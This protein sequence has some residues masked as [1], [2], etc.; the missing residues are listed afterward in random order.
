MREPVTLPV[1]HAVP[2]RAIRGKEITLSASVP[3][4]SEGAIL[5]TLTVTV[6]GDTPVTVT[7]RETERFDFAEGS[8]ASLTA[9]LPA[10]LTEACETVV[11]T[12]ASDGTVLGRYEVPFLKTRSNAEMPPL[13]FTE[14]V[15]R[16]SSPKGINYLE[17]MNPSDKTVDLYDYKLVRVDAEELQDVE[18]IREMLITNEKGTFLAPGEV[19]VLRIVPV[20]VQNTNPEFLSVEAFVEGV[21]GVCPDPIECDPDAI[22]IVNVVNAIPDEETGKLVAAPGRFDCPIMPGRAPHTI[23]ITARDGKPTEAFHSLTYGLVPFELETPTRRA[24]VWGLDPDCPEKAVRLSAAEFMTPGRLAAGQAYPDFSD[25]EAPTIIPLTVLPYYF[26]KGDMVMKFAVL[27]QPITGAALHVKD[28]D[29][30][31]HTFEAFDEGEDEVYE[32]TVPYRFLSSLEKFEYYITA[33]D[34]IREASLGSETHLYSRVLYDNAGPSVL[35]CRPARG[36]AVEGNL[37]PEVRIAYFDRAGINVLKSKLR[38]DGKDVSRKALWYDGEVVYTPE[39]PLSY[40]EHRISAVLYDMLGNKAFYRSE[41]SIVDGTELNCYRGEVHAHTMESDGSALPEHAMVHARDV[42]KADYFAVTEHSHYL[43]AAAYDRQKAVADLYDD[44][45]K[46]AALYGWEMTWNNA[47]GFW[48]HMNVLGTDD[49]VQDI[50]AVDMPSLYEYLARRPESVAMFNHPGL[51]WGNFD[52]YSGRRPEVD[53]QVCLAEI[54]GAHADL[55]YADMLAKGW[56]TAP[57]ANEDNHAMNWTTATKTTGYVLAPALT[58]ENVMEAFRLRRTYTTGDN[59]LKLK[60]KVNGQWLGS[61]LKDPDVL[62]VEVSMETELLSGIGLVQIVAEDNIVVAQIDLGTKTAFDWKVELPALY[63]YYYVR[64]YGD[65]IYTVT[66]PVWIERENPISI[67][68]IRVFHDWAQKTPNDVS[69]RIDNCGETAV[70]DLSVNFY[71]S[72]VGG[73]VAPIA[74]PLETVYLDKIKGEDTACVTRRFPNVTRR[75]R[76]TVIVRGTVNGRPVQSTD[77]VLLSPLDI[78]AVAPNTAPITLP[79]GTEVKNPFSYVQLFNTS[80]EELDLSECALRL[81]SVTGRAPT[82]EA[83]LP[84][85]GVK[86]PPRGTFIV[87]RRPKDAPLA[88]ADFNARYDTHLVEG[89]EILVTEQRIVSAGNSMRRIDVVAPGATLARVN[90]NMGTDCPG[91]DTEEGNVLYFRYKPNRTGTAVKVTNKGAA[92]PDLVTDEQKARD[93]VYFEKKEEEKG[94][95]HAEKRIAKA[96]KKA[97]APKMAKSSA[98]TL[99][100]ASAAGA[101][102]ATAAILKALGKKK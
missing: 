38:V 65:K 67:R 101:A 15:A 97:A 42:G 44:P 41:F 2:S 60:Y 99:A 82:E 8:F 10:S 9:V 86:I 100:L 48:G 47:N 53:R 91:K 59:T 85:K 1:Y 102:A 17:V 90:Y 29:G 89:E 26:A 64:I 54:K 36:Y 33:S 69:V 20:A 87:W 70:K 93:F 31:F 81:W 25:T 95:K 61:T 3:I 30:K 71:L 22:R 78:T 62:S 39:K 7:M 98:L 80:S 4:R 5:P 77:Y 52:E 58:R 28:N 6:E 63:D 24:S 21:K 16:G 57:V 73:F 12:L 79:D 40:G 49:I 56:H 45:G 46:F 23:G 11:Y 51:T 50:D 88:V 55:E 74:E 43:S 34:S 13:V 92:T 37:I 83:T 72:D 76:V 18:P 75:R 19:A 35:S 66:A 14:M 96:E 84:L 27:G 32:A 68:H 94:A